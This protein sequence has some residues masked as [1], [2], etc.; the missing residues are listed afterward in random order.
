MELAFA[1]TTPMI[2]IFNPSTSRVAIVPQ[3]PEPMPVGVWFPCFPQTS[4]PVS[5]PKWQAVRH[6]AGSAASQHRQCAAPSRI[7]QE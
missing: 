1:A 3:M 5:S 4:M 2:F 6:I 7:R